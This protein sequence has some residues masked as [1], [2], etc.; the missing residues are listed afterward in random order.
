MTRTDNLNNYLIDIANAI[1]EK[2]NIDNIIP[3]NTFD[4][5]IRS[6]Q[7][8][9][10]ING[11]IR[12]EKAGEDINAGDFI[13]WKNKGYKLS[14]DSSNTLEISTYV[15]GDNFYSDT[16]L[17]NIRGFHT[18]K[19]TDN[20]Y[21]TSQIINIGTNSK[22]KF[23]YEVALYDTNTNVRLSRI[24]LFS[25]SSEDEYFNTGI[26]YF[27]FIDSNTVLM[28]VILSNKFY[29]IIVHIG[30]DNILTMDTPEV[31]ATG[32]YANDCY[33]SYKINENNF[34]FLCKYHSSAGN[35]KTGYNG[36]FLTLGET[37]TFKYISLNSDKYNNASYTRFLP[38]ENKIIVYIPNDGN[39][40]FYINVIDVDFE[41]KTMSSC[42]TNLVMY[43]QKKSPISKYAQGQ[44]IFFI[45]QN[46]FFITLLG[47]NHYDLSVFYLEININSDNTVSIIREG[48]LVNLAKHSGEGCS[49]YSFKI[50]DN[51]K[52]IA[53]AAD[54]DGS[55]KT[56]YF[57]GLDYQDNGQLNLSNKTMF[58]SIADVDEYWFVP[59][60]D[61]IDLIYY[62]PSGTTT[63]KWYKFNIEDLYCIGKASS[64]SDILGVA[65][66]NGTIGSKVQYYTL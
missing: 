14:L 62:I 63:R 30:E 65:K 10:S 9:I 49:L 54:G 11:I 41:E 57:Y 25:S 2:K 44:N 59:F 29:K 32:W 15:Y 60:S 1:R 4:D 26:Y 51:H 45:D 3:A 52:I 16:V 50:L 31:I 24:V 34:F 27:D 48:N 64:I 35:W 66:N 37:N 5:E 38:N 21:L 20:M 13:K 40:Y 18:L 46:R 22:I 19:Y 42:K 6:I 7:S 12:E 55:V 17:G 61:I 23:S 56:N 53:W 47:R 43:M 58:S 36:V 39:D 28:F 33:G 8:G